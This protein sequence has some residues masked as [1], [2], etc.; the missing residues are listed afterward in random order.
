VGDHPLMDAA[1]A[2]RAGLRACWLNR[3]VRA[4]PLDQAPPDLQ[5]STLTALADWL[6]AHLETR[7]RDAR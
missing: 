5:F 4:W 3:E 2:M 1:G 6:D 7:A